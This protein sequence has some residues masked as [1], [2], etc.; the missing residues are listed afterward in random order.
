MTRVPHALVAAPA[1]ALALSLPATAQYVDGAN[2]IPAKNTTA[3][4]GFSENVDFSDVDGDGDM[5]AVIAEG[6]DCCNQ[7]NRIWINQGGLQGGTVGFFSDESGARFPLGAD[8]SRDMDFVD[9]DNDGDDDIYISNTSAISNQGNR[10]W[11]NQGGMQGGSAGFFTDETATRWLNVGLNN[12]TTL[13]SSVASNLAITSGKFQ[14]SFVDWSCDCVFGDLDGDGFND[15]VH[16]TY[17][18]TFGGDAPSRIFLNDGTGH[19]EEFNPSGFQLGGTDIFDGD[20]G[21]WCEGTHQQGTNNT[22]GQQCDISDTPLGVELG[23]MDLDWDIDILQGARNETPRLYIN[24]LSQLGS[25]A[26]R[27]ITSIGIPSATGGGNYE[28]ELGDF[29]NDNDLDLYGLNWAGLSDITAIN[30]LGSWGPKVT[31]SGSSA[32]DNE[33]DFLD[34]NGDGRL[35][36]FVG[37]FSGANKLYENDGPPNW[38]FTN[39]SGPMLP[40]DLGTALG[41]DSTDIDNDGDQDIIVAND[42]G[43]ENQLLINTGNVA[44]QTAARVVSQQAPDRVPSATPTPIRARVYDNASWDFLRY[45]AT[46]IEYQVNGGAVQTAPMWFIGGQ[47]FYGELDGNLAGAISYRVKST[48]HT[49]NTGTSTALSFNSNSPSINYCTAGTSASGCTASVSTSGTPSATASSGFNLLA[50]DVEGNKDGLFFFGANGRQANP[51]GSGTS[52]QCVV[53]PV[54]RGGLLLGIGTAGQCD[55]S[56]SQDLNALWTAK[57][58]KNPGAGAV[59]QAQLWYRD[60][61]NTSNKKTSMSDGV[62]FTVQP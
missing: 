61:L 17:G 42:N 11:V 19:F 37:N 45:N 62:E 41:L 50:T 24:R 49:G 2:Q 51:W 4:S 36:I 16:T 54:V 46:V 5:D 34:Y 47:M 60:P 53:P 56:F 12:G 55:G 29:D 10:F 1:A 31:L 48:D 39:V 44:D 21:L 30:N 25:L 38:T 22:N 15:L 33:G 23:D 35:D 32:D 13:L 28:Q 14:G 3:N 9:I 26:F 27:D 43:T 8:D 59:T 20:P 6:G 52:F 18:G 58:T 57:P 7:R 40:P